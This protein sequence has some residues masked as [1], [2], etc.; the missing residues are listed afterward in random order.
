MYT[1]RHGF[2]RNKLYQQV[3]N[4]A[5]HLS[6]TPIRWSYDEN[7]C[8]LYMFFE[9]SG[10]KYLVIQK[11]LMGVENGSFRTAVLGDGREFILWN[12]YERRLATA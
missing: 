12:D 7:T 5:K 4:R 1:S 6:N 10:C 2:R 11:A 8:K 3:K 9:Q